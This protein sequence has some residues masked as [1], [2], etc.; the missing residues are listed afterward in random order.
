MTGSSRAEASS[1]KSNFGNGTMPS[2]KTPQ[3]LHERIHYRPDIDGL[4][5]I[6]VFIVIFYHYGVWPWTGGFVGVDV[7]FVISGYLISSIIYPEVIGRRFSI[8]DF[9]ARRIRRI[10][11]ALGATLLFAAIAGAIILFPEDL[12]KFGESLFATALFSSNFE[13]WREA[14]YFDS[15]AIS[16]PLL[17]TWSLAVEEQFYLF[18]PP[19]LLAIRWLRRVE[20]AAPILATLGAV[21]LAIAVVVLRTSPTAAFYLL[22]ARAWEPLL[23]AFLLTSDLKPPNALLA[24][25]CAVMGMIAIG[26]A[27][28]DFT[29]ST[30]FPG[31]S[32]ILPCGGTALLI[33]AGSNRSSLVN[34]IL[35]ARPLVVGGLISYS[36][37]LWHWPLLVFAT[38]ASSNG[39]T[40]LSKALLIAASVV[41]AYASWRF[42]ERPFR[43]RSAI[44][45]RRELFYAA[46]ISTLGVVALGAILV[47][48]RGLPGR[49]PKPV[50]VILAAASDYHE[51]TNCEQ[52]GQFKIC[53]VGPTSVKEPDIL[54]WGDSIANSMLPAIA[55][56]LD[57]TRQSAYYFELNGC[58][59]LLDINR[60]S[61]PDCREFNSNVLRFAVRSKVHTVVLIARWALDAEGT[62]YGDEPGEFVSLQDARNQDPTANNHQLFLLG[63]TRTVSTLIDA[64]KRIVLMGSI[65]EIGRAVPSLLAK[66]HLLG[67]V[68]FSGPTV[69]EFEDR[70]RFVRHTMNALHAQ[71][72]VTVL[73]PASI[74]CKTTCSLELNGE[75]LY[76][77]NHHLST[78]GAKL[79]E[80]LML[81]AI[82]Q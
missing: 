30:P 25:L 22:P 48:T 33:F 69:A 2:E 9:Y 57:R 67:G 40:D 38:Y 70:Q 63:L 21:S 16:K 1:G 77:D 55:S 44:L 6:A 7:F 37:Y 39:I 19:L 73:D 23:G 43:G 65:P 13:F 47:L 79:I 18:F 49:Y 53:R 62:H 71:F 80:P 82:S 61:T 51:P 8:L 29:R 34:A 42:V 54:F 72:G 3:A 35:S 15:S 46:A 64:R 68:R 78:R 26:W 56:A 59:P 17:H 50:Q 74:L 31:L 20:S 5:A 12:I 14:N 66:E 32:A 76:S 36:L 10:F 24:N 60:P 28:L 41:L 27:A 4:R 45:S 52:K 75:P 58:P 81:K 11:P